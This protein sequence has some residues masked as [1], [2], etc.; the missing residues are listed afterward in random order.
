MTTIYALASAKG[1]AGVAVMRVSG[2]E[3]GTALAT[4]TGK[5]V[6][7]ARQAALRSFTAPSTGTVIDRGLAIWF[8][9]PASFTGE[10]V[11]ELHL[12][13]GPAVIAAMVAVLDGLGLVPAEPGEFS[14]RAFENG[15]LDLTEAEGIADLVGA[16]TEAQRLQALRQMDGA[17]GAVYEG[18]RGDLIRALAF[19]EADLDFPDEDLPGGLAAQVVPALDRLSTEIR[20]HL[21]DDRRG[22]ALRD[23]FQVVITGAPN[24]GK[25]SLLNA[26]ARRDVA[27]V[28]EVAGTTR[29]II[30]VRLD[31][32]GYPLTLVDTAGLRDSE[33]IIEQEGVRRARARADQADLRL[34]I[35]ESGEDIGLEQADGLI[36]IN[37]VDIARPSPIPGAFLISVR[38]GEGI[39]VLLAALEERVIAMMGLRDV[40]SLTRSRHRRALEDAVAHLDRACVGAS[41]EL[42]PELVAEDVRLAARALGRITGRVDVED[43]L[44]VVFGEFCIGK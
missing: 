10:D 15:K 20:A 2:E 22:E 42:E 6:P 19:L 11:A 23:G 14:R 28:S 33:D 4:L 29:D 35:Y 27:I 21:A 40:P 36:V 34:Q 17:L 5:D 24:V 9:A 31:L 13:G 39:D 41:G 43:V 3:A 8:P 7:P 18:W 12:H 30:E 16:E 1:R 44:D 37:K 32:G 25:S 26:L 38:T